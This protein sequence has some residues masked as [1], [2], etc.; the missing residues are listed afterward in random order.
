MTVAIKIVAPKGGPTI[1][2]IGGDVTRYK[3]SGADTA[4]AF[5]LLEQI[6]P[7]GHGPWRHV[8]S[9][10]EE[11]FY[12]TD[13]KF[14]FEVGDARFVATAG[15]MVLGPRA[16][17]HRFWNS[18]PVPGKLSLL[19]TPT[20]LEPF[21]EEFSRLLAEHPGDLATQAELAGR[22]GMQFV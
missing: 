11:S 19:I 9:R 10:E 13:G 7:P 1:S 4:G 18:G 21:F 16:I 14:T 12:I 22:Y 8:H 5:A 6:V 17:P 3:V 20:G 15:A 2:P